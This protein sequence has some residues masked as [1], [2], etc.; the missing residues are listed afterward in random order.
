[1]RLATFNIESLDVPPD[2][3]VGLAERAEI[4]RPQLERLDADVLCLQ[5]V[6]SQRL[7]GAKARTLCALEELLKGTQYA[8][9]ALA[10]SH[11]ADG[12]ALADVHNLVILSRFPICSQLELRHTLVSPPAYQCLTAVPNDSAPRQIFFDR[13]ALVAELA[14]PDSGKLTVIN[15]H[16]RAPL[17]SAV[18]GQKIS[19]SAWKSTAAWAEGFF[20]SSLKRSAQALEVRLAVD[21]MF[22]ADVH[23]YIA[24]CGDFNAEDHETPIKILQA[25]EDDTGNGHLATRSLVIA[26]RALSQDRRFSV[27]HRGRPQMLDHILVTR[28]LAGHLKGIDVHN[29]AL[30][31]EATATT[32]GHAMLGSY[33]APLVAEFSIP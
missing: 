23:R 13:P 11:G 29:E 26:D 33:H 4:L 31:D 2:A 24:V 10:A 25:A 6:N 15:L 1:M 27:L 9:Y 3:D 28:S 32:E 20:L 30:S 12:S 18:R 8:S 14:L 21:S 17:A 7:R 19:A 22:D 16:L 5:E